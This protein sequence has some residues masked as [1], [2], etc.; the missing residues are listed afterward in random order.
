[1]KANIVKALLVTM[2]AIVA[3][4]A[5][6][7]KLI[8]EPLGFWSQSE[9]L[10]Q[11]DHFKT[12]Y[13]KVY[14]SQKEEDF[15]LGIFIQTV[16]EIL[17][18]NNDSSQTYKQGVNFMS[19]LTFEE[20][21]SRYLVDSDQLQASI[22]SLNATEAHESL[23]VNDTDQFSK[24]WRETEGVVTEV[25]NQGQ[26][27]SC[28]AFSTTGVLEGYFAINKQTS[29]SLS[30]QELVDCSRRYGN[31]GCRGGLDSRALQYVKENG[32][33]LEEDYKYRARDQNC[34][35]DKSKKRFNIDS[36][37]EFYNLTY[38]SYAAIIAKNPTSIYYE[39][40]NKFLRYSSGVYKGDN[41]CKTRIN[42]ALLAV[43]VEMKNTPDYSDDD[44]EYIIVKNSWSTQWGEKG[45][46]KL[47][48]TSI[49]KQCGMLQTTV[50][51]K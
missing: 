2:L 35:V 36:F 44:S 48:K 32:I 46:I 27:G 12:S 33:G 41:T 16:E 18:H 50:F 45:Y 39:V 23:N 22:A 17:A 30:E 51:V 1:M 9:Y 19:D 6:N 34:S 4:N 13:N 24:D 37:V 49:N 14:E 38:N 43:G 29:V 15:R 31:F 8:R 28:W 47:G 10:N 3:V 25:K 26:C 11:F 40:T 42:H 7:K 5:N 21:K 20:I